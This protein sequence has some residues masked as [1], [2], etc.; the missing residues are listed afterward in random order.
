VDTRGG[1]K[2]WAIAGALL[3]LWAVGLRI[4]NALQYPL[5]FGF[6]APANWEYISGLLKSWRL[7]APGDGWSTSHPPLLY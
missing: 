7:P 6:D 5:H 3:A 2:G 1:S 4:N